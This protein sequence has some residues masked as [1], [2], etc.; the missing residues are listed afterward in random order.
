[1]IGEVPVVSF[2]TSAH[3]RLVGPDAEPIIARIN[4][5]L[6]FRFAGS[7]VEELSATARPEDRNKLF[8]SCQSLQRGPSECLLPS[9][10]LTEQLVSAHFADPKTF[11]WK[12]VNVR[13]SDCERA[14]RDPR[15]FDDEQTAGEQRAFQRERKMVGKQDRERKRTKRS[16]IQAFFAKHGE[17]PPTTFQ[18]A[19]SRL[20]KSGRSVWAAAERF[21]DRVTKRDTDDATVEEFMNIC[22]PFRALVYAM[23]IPWYD[24]WIRDY[25]TGEKVKAGSNDLFMS[26]Y[27]PYCDTFVTD[28]GDQE[29]SLRAVATAAG[30]ETKVLSYEDF[31]ARFLVTA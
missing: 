25:Q 11:N 17:A 12:T 9:N 22:P 14:I 24:E 7:C 4:S 18:P 31:C 1:M 2:D 27:L 15:F 28:D 13:W 21:Y 8:A 10:L 16:E 30:L 20:E 3:N 29:K 23:F 26:V 19:I 6:W 5:E